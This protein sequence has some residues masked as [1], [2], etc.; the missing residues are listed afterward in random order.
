MHLD[1][2]LPG[3]VGASFVVLLVGLVMRRLGQPSVVGYLLAGVLLGSHGLGLLDD[4]R[5]ATRL[6]EFGGAILLGIAAFALRSTELTLPFVGRVRDDHELQVFAAFV[7]CVSGSPP[8]P[9]LRA[10]PRRWA[11]LSRVSLSRRPS[12]PS[13]ST[14]RW[15]R[16]GWCSSRCSSRLSA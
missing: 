15:S 13:G 16:C 10:C 4:P 5:M 12:R 3:L 1:P 6:G 14:T 8:R 9:P 11:P 2:L 7:L